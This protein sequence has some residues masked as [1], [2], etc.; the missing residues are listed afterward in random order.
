MYDGVVHYGGQWVFAIENKPYGDVREYQL[1]PNIEDSEG[2]EVDPRL[3]VLVWKDLIHR[4]H[5]L[6]ESDWLD[7]TQQQLVEDFLRYAQEEFPT[8][9][10]YPTLKQCGDDLDKLNRRCEDLMQELAP[11]RLDMRR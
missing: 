5:T 6:G 9:N 7:Y 11:D 1:H 10:P 3:V 2:M 4:L 8:I